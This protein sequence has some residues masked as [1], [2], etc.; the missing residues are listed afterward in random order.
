M[1]SLTTK[2]VSN[3]FGE[4]IPNNTLTSFA[5]ILTEQ[6]NLEGQW[7]LQFQNYPTPQCTKI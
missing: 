3:A 2:L 7:R 5:N 6:V 1:D 4:L